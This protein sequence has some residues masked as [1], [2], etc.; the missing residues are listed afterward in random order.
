[1]CD[2][3]RYYKPE[4]NIFWGGMSLLC[5]INYCSRLIVACL[6]V[7]VRRPQKPGDKGWVGRARVP[8]PSTRD[9]VVRPKWN[10]EQ[11]FKKVRCEISMLQNFIEVGRGILP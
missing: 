2:Y 10:V 3:Q 11:D 9:Y 8:M 4:W 7:F 1:M 6:I 5:L